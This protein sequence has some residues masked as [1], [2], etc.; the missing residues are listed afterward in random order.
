MVKSTEQRNHTPTADEVAEAAY[1]LEQAGQLTGNC[2]DRAEA[3]LER[4]R[5]SSVQRL[6]TG[7]VV[8]DIGEGP[9]YFFDFGT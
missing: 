2:T 3:V 5:R 8:L 6:A 9:D 1:E 7:S 4:A